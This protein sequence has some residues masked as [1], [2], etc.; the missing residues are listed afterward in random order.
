MSAVFLAVG[1]FAGLWGIFWFAWDRYADAPAWLLGIGFV[2]LL[3]G[4]ATS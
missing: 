1:S 4:G 2:C 3:I